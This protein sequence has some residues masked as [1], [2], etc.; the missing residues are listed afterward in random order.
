VTRTYAT[1]DSVCAGYRSV[2]IL[3]SS[4]LIVMSFVFSPRL[5]AAEPKAGVANQHFVCNVGY[6]LQECQ[7]AATVLRNGLVRYPM[8][9]LGEWTWV[10]VRTE[11]WKQFLSERKF[12]S[13]NPAFSYLPKRETFLDGALVVRASIRGVQLSVIWRMPIEDLLD[14][15]IRHELAHAFCNERD[16]TTAERAA[17]ALKKGLPLSC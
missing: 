15:A 3:L 1:C 12:D 8:A 6:T 4:V 10:L 5:L 2:L 14:L 9:A 17:I 16:E 11:D 7:A 13:N